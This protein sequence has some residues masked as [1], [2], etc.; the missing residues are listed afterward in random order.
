MSLGQLAGAELPADLGSVRLVPVPGTDIGRAF[1][2]RV[3][4]D[5]P[6]RAEAFLSLRELDIYW[7]V[8]LEDAA[9]WQPVEERFMEGRR[10]RI[11]R[12]TP[13]LGAPL[14]DI[15]G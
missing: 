14:T 3:P 7:L 5:W 13:Y 6:E 9:E 11:L 4:A 12:G 8:Q 2:D 15:L 1:E 10:N